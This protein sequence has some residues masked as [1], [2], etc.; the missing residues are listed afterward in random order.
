MTTTT[1]AAPSTSWITTTSGTT[2]AP[3]AMPVSS[4]VATSEVTASTT[5]ESRSVTS[6]SPTS[7]V[8]MTSP[9]PVYVAASNN[10]ATT[11]NYYF[12]NKDA[13]SNNNYTSHVNDVVPSYSSLPIVAKIQTPSTMPPTP[14]P[15]MLI[16]SSHFPSSSN[17]LLLPSQTDFFFF[18]LKQTSPFSR[19]LS[20][21]LNPVL[22]LSSSNCCL[23]I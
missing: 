11:E 1:F 22:S 18:L 7:V 20:S 12:S 21:L 14:G 9:V 19:F 15:G 8:Q 10:L 17:R 23:I 2:M 16:I 3:T 4:S 13:E 6:S 5:T